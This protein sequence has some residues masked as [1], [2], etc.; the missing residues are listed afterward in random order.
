MHGFIFAEIKS[1]VESKFDSKTWFAILQNAGLSDKTYENFLNY[2]D[3]EAVAIV[4]TASRMTGTPVPDILRD[5]GVF[6]G[7]DL[8][9][10]YRPVI[11]PSWRTIEFLANVEQ[12]IH[13]VVRTRNRNAH[14]PA[15]RCEASGPG[16]VTITY[17]SARRLCAIAHGIVSGVAQHYGESVTIE[18]VACMNRGDARCEIRVRRDG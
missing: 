16:E 13:H 7:G 18:D 8:M 3:A 5:F 17:Q 6:L 9:R 2:D 15:L 11:D 14:P 10:V 12:T 1:Y 4:S